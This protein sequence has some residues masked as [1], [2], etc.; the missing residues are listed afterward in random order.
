MDKKEFE[1]QKALGLL[2]TYDGYISGK[3]SYYE[4]YTVVD[5]SLA[6]AKRQMNTILKRLQKNSKEHLSVY[7]V[8]ESDTPKKKRGINGFGCSA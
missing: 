4:V 8:T 1:I 7:L 5:V 6:G 2:K 3:N